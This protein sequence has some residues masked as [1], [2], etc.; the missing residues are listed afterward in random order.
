MSRT[1]EWQNLNQHR[2]YP[3]V[4][5]SDVTIVGKGP[6]SNAVLL[7]FMLT[8][9]LHAGQP[10]RLTHVKV[11]DVGGVDSVS[12]HFKLMVDLDDLVLTV[13]GTAADPYRAIVYTAQDYVAATFGPVADMLAWGYGTYTFVN[14]PEIEPTRLGFQGGHRVLSIRAGGTV[15]PRDVLTGV[16]YIQ[17]G[18]NCQALVKDDTV[19][20]NA[21]KGAGAGISCDELDATVVSCGDVLLRVSGLKGSGDG[22]FMLV[23]GPGVE[24]TTEPANHTVIIRSTVDPTQVKRCG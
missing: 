2:R 23:G 24:V 7:D 16:I 17:E 12:F 10:V 11:E 8:D 20:L 14:P 19:V 1:I 21:I 9:F 3:L 13:P 5:D 6:M 18:Y 22:N 4:E 15:L